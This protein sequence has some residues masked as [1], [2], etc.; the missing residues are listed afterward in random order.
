MRTSFSLALSALV[1]LLLASL[2]AEPITPTNRT[3]E[4]LYAELRQLYPQNQPHDPANQQKDFLVH[5]EFEVNL[6]ASSPWVV[7]PIAMAWD[8]HHRLWVINAP[9]YPQVMPGQRHTDFISVLEDVDGDG[10]AD[11]CTIFYDQL[12]VP[13]GLALGDGGVYVAN[14]PDLLFLKDSKGGLRADTRRVFL[15]GFGTEDNHH[16]ISA[17]RW[18]PG[19]WLYFMSGI[20]LHTQVETPHGLVRLDDGG[21]FQLRPRSQRLQMYN[22]GTA[23]N[24]WGLAFDRWGQAFLTEGPQGGIW[25]LN[26][27]HIHG[28]PRDRTPET[29]APKACGNEFLEGAHWDAK[30]QGVMVLNAFKNKTVNL[31]QFSDDGAGFATKELQPLLLQSKEP[32]F[33]P[34]DVKLGPDG[35][36]YVADFFQEIIGHMQYEFRDPRRDHLNGRIWRI[37][38]K[39]RKPTS[40]IDLT[41]LSLPELCAQLKSPEA[42]VRDMTRRVLYER[43]A[44]DRPAVAAA[45]R[46]LA[47]Q[48]VPSEP[49]SEHHRLEALWAL[50]TIEEVDRSL[51]QAVL[52]SPE[53]RA[54]AAACVVLRDWHEQIP[55]A[56]A[57][58]AERVGDEH[59]R[60]RMEAICSL[61][62]V[63]QPQTINAVARAA[64]LPMDRTLRHAFVHT[65]RSLQPLWQPALRAGALDLLRHPH[66]LLAVL[67]S[68]PSQESARLV[69]E[70][71]QRE[72]LAAE[73][74]ETLVQFIAGSGQPAELR[75][76]LEPPLRDR[77]MMSEERRS[78][79]LAALAQAVRS[80]RLKLDADWAAL[81]MPYALATQSAEVRVPALRLL[82]SVPGEEV[83]DALLGAAL[84]EAAELPARLAALDSLGERP[85]VALAGPLEP[86][87]SGKTRQ[88]QATWHAIAALAAAD[89]ARAADYLAD[90]LTRSP[91]ASDCG[92]ALA[93]LLGQSQGAALLH[94]ALADKTLHVDA[95]KLALRWLNGS[96]HQAPELVTRFSQAAGIGSPSRPLTSADLVQLMDEVKK[97]G[98]PHR[99]EAVFRRKDLACLTCHAIAGGGAQIGPDLEGIGTSS[100]LDYL[101]ESVLLPNKAIREGYA[102][103]VV[104]TDQGRLYTGIPI[105]R[106]SAELILKDAATRRVIRLP[107]KSIE[108]TKDAGSIMPANLV[109]QMTRSELVDLVAFLHQLGRP[110]PFATPNLPILRSWR[111][112][113]PVPPVLAGGQ[114]EPTPARKLLDDTLPWQ[115]VYSRVSGAFPVDEMA[116]DRVLAQARIDVGTAGK[117]RLRIDEP[118]GLMLWLDEQP[119]NVTAATTLDVSAGIH[120][121]TFRVDRTPRGKQ[122]F[123]VQLEE[124]PGSPARAR[125]MAWD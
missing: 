5:P 47:A 79:L 125:V 27:G 11:R 54:R 21:T 7:N 121:L 45:I 15:S 72:A 120:W 65:V 40:R 85:G 49:D 106:T 38:Q 57:W 119:V 10:R 88:R 110:G 9:M 58:L 16:A 32:Y 62:F 36:L 107:A 95:A 118:E 26:P 77:L 13:T 109:E 6:F 24:P 12:Y 1:L 60:V 22:V 61:S 50:Q 102:G 111:V 124:I 28:H 71:L 30:Y 56:A 8:E 39:G 81:V 83:T 98:N 48:L 90:H 100:P 33:R 46:S 113:D 52:A 70:L 53:P 59:P 17:F 25:H 91:G 76:L 41:R 101:V 18:G 104:L 69:L 66:R 78:R 63:R 103:I 55:E 105:K 29:P 31:Y 44:Q 75:R 93:A 87:L 2:A 123:T 64:D 34:V 122:G 23:T 117:L 4:E 51:L 108:Q 68:I 14:Q 115:T 92:P 37:T 96:G 82:G 42:Y 97:H 99:G 94:Q 80:R 74:Q 67:S 84:D 19:G 112:L 116:S 114:P 86:L 35:A 73:Q 3:P 20:F 43:S 89:A